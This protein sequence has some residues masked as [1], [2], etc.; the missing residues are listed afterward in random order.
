MHKAGRLSDAEPL[1]RRALQADPKQFVPPA[2][3][4]L[5]LQGYL[6]LSNRVSVTAGLY[7]LTNQKYWLWNNVVGFTSSQPNLERFAE[8]G[9][10][11]AASLTVRF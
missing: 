5:D 1:Y 7:N 8:P 3:F 6:N 9:L 4:R 10:Y 11:G 2:F